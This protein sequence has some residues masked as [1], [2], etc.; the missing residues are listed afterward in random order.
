VH[1]SNLRPGDASDPGFGKCQIP[2][3]Q[4][5][6]HDST[7]RASCSGQSLGMTTAPGSQVEHRAARGR[8][9]QVTDRFK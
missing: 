7:A 1:R 6:Q 9:K 5:A 8:T 4:V 3:V 2:G